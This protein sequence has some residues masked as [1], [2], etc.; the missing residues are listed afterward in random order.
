MKKI[1]IKTS[2]VKLTTII[3]ILE[4]NSIIIVDNG[5]VS[6]EDRIV[7]KANEALFKSVYKKLLKKQIDKY[8]HRKDFAIVFTYPEAAV[9]WRKLKDAQIDDDYRL[10]V[11]YNFNTFLHQQLI[12]Q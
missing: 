11:C 6:M 12:S 10:A 2:F 3:N 7:I 8:E 5:L 1:T 9:L 4:Q